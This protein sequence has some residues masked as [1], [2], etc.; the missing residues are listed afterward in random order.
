MI[1]VAHLAT[2]VTVQP[3]VCV[4]PWLAQAEY[5]KVITNSFRTKPISIQVKGIESGITP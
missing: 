3:W 5:F 4:R 2:V 1:W